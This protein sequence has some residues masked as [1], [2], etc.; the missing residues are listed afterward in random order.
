[1]NY[2]RTDTPNNQDPP[3]EILQPLNILADQGAWTSVI[4]EIKKLLLKFPNSSS[5]KNIEGDAYYYLSKTDDAM[6]SYKQAVKLD[7]ECAGIYYKLGIIA[8]KKGDLDLAIAYFKQGIDYNK[9]FSLCHYSLAN[10]FYFAGNLT[11]AIQNYEI[12]IKIDP[13]YADAHAGLG[14]IYKEQGQLVKAI[15]SYQ[16]ALDT[17]PEWIEVRNNL[18]LTFLEN[19]NLDEAIVHFKKCI[20]SRR[21]YVHSYNN[22]GLALKEKGNISEALKV[23]RQALLIQPNFS[24]LNNNV[25]NILQ[26]QG[27]LDEAIDSYKKAIASKPDYADAYNNLGTAYYELGNYEAAVENYQQA[28]KFHSNFGQAFYNLGIVLNKIKEFDA[29]ISYFNKAITLNPNDSESLHQ[30]AKISFQIGRYDIALASFERLLVLIPS[31][32]EAYYCIA[33]IQFEFGQNKLAFASIE[34][35]LSQKPNE[36]M[37]TQVYAQGLA[38]VGQHKA[39]IAM[40]KKI[41]RLNANNADIL[42]DLI[43]MSS[44]DPKLAPKELFKDF[45]KVVNKD[46]NTPDCGNRNSNQDMVALIGYGR[47]GS[48]FLHSL[49]DGHPNISTLPGYFFKGWFNTKTWEMIAPRKDVPNW[50]EKLANDICDYFEPQ[51]DASSKKNVIGTPNGHT[52][53]LANDWGFNKMGLNHSEVLK[54]DQRKF[55][56]QFSKLLDHHVTI[57]QSNCFNMIHK[58]FDLAYRENHSCHQSINKTIFYHIHNP[59]SFEHA[60]FLNYYPKAKILY[61]IRHPIQMLESWVKSYYNELIKS[62][63]TFQKNIWCCK[64][65]NRISFSFRPLYNPLNSLAETKG[66]KLEDIK[67][68]PKDTLVSIANW[69]GVKEHHSLYKSEFMNRQYSRPSAN[70]N[71]ITGFD[72]QSIDV[73]LGRFFGERDIEILETLF[74]PLLSSYQYTKLGQKE[75]SKKLKK[76]RPWL[77]EPFQFEKDIYA[78]V[79]QQDKMIKEV[80]YFKVLRQ[81]LINS[82]ETLHDTGTYPHLIPPLSQ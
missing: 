29:A 77:E 40:F 75:F 32:T 49:I 39:S 20:V 25:G 47:S 74:W 35:G 55:K 82:W 71:S 57:D 24:E 79:F 43:Q 19:G 23:Y 70:F 13:Y 14:V 50:K 5:L 2:I 38:S 37:L 59:N 62:S 51:F 73:P 81:H 41:R 46:Q 78:K 36:E 28:I 45:C 9:D 27:K 60:N 34:K 54:L 30:L 76:I 8:D 12:A 72:P 68:T 65:V 48:L 64:I 58:A 11:A 16:Q 56:K 44:Y 66:V 42:A 21:T 61:I 1:M 22:L 52:S 7:P 15:T 4:A 63:D 18:G 33:H 69:I 10:C 53:W 3:K 17:K 80:D 26:N 67:R 31:C 6:D